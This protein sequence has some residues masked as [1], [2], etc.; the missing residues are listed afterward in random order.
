LNGGFVGGSATLT[1]P[2][3]I[4]R[5]GTLMGSGTLNVT[6]STLIDEN[7]TFGKTLS[8]RTLRLGTFTTWRGTSFFLDAGARIENPANGTLQFEVDVDISGTVLPTFVNDGTLT[9]TGAPRRLTLPGSFGNAGTVVYRLGGTATGE[10][11]RI[12]APAVTLGGT[13]DVR[14]INGF[15][16]ASGQQFNVI[17]FGT[18][19]GQFTTL[20]GNGENYDVTYGTSA[21]TLIKP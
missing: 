21:V 15:T 6:G 10:F 2:T 20:I 18:R 17:T 16:P 11:D 8:E 14:L 12:A 19:T 5:D 7:G 9:F 13:L 3:F 4:W 1:T